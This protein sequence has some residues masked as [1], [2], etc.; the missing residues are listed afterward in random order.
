MPNSAKHE[1]TAAASDLHRVLYRGLPR[2]RSSFLIGRLDVQQI[3]ADLSVTHQAIYRWLRTGRLPAR[4]IRQLL[5]LKGS[6]LTAE[7]LLPFVSR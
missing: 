4:R 1:T 2:H 6:T 5:D 7:M 3:V